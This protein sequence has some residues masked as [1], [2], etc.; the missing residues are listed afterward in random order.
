M[1]NNNITSKTIARGILR[2]LG[3][4]ALVVAITWFLYKIRSVLVYV[5]VAAVLS[6]IA[7]PFLKFLKEKL[8]FP[9]LLAVI[10]VM[11]FF[12]SIIFGIISMFIP[13]IIQ[14]SHHISILNTGEFHDNIKELIDEVNKFFYERGVNLSD[15]F[16]SIDLS[17]NLKSIPGLLN[18]VIGT[19]GTL[20]I[21]LFSV[22]FITFFFMKDSNILYEVFLAVTPDDKEERILKSFKKI[23]PLLSRYFIGLIIQ[24]SILFTIYSVILLIFGVESA[25]VIAFLSAILNIIPYV[26][27]LIGG[28]LMLTLTMTSNL[29]HDFQTHLLPTTIY[30]L[31]GYIIAQLIDNFFSQPIIFS[32]SVKS[33]PLEIFLVII[34]DGLLFGI[35]GMIIAVPT[36]TA[37]KVILK[38][39]LA[40]NEVVKQLT[41]HYD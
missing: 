41:K 40:E 13:L 23:S 34:I 31:I 11:V 2:A 25:I 15:K 33:H 26:G 39:F 19:L 22:L 28:I 14:Q 4:I 9:N 18:S 27:P 20:S 36:Y 37:L 16:K 21:G 5:A 12:I 17:S 30:V 8:K 6:L 32:K 35:I 1:N 29:E 3:T 10:T 7:R 38:E 24:I